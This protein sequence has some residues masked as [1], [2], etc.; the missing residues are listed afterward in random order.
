MASSGG[1]NDKGDSGKSD[2]GKSDS[3]KSDSKYAFDENGVAFSFFMA[4]LVGCFVVPKTWNLL[5]GGRGGTKASAEHSAAVKC[6]CEGCEEW[7]ARQAKRSKQNKGGGWL[8]HLTLILGWL[9]VAAS[10]AV[11]LNGKIE[12]RMYDPYAVLG[13]P[14]GA[15]EEVVRKAYKKL[16][17]KMHPD[18]LKPGMDKAATEKAFVEVSRAYQTLT[19]ADMNRRWQEE[20]DPDG[21][22]AY[23]LG[24]ALPLWMV[25]GK[26]SIILLFLYLGLFGIGVPV[27]VSRLWNRSRS[28]TKDKLLHETMQMFYRELKEGMNSRKVLEFVAAATEYQKLPSVANMEGFIAEM[29]EWCREQSVESYAVPKK[30][31]GNAAAVKAHAL[32]F[33]H[34]HRY[35]GLSTLLKEQQVQVVELAVP[36]TLGALQICLARK[37]VPVA[38]AC[39]HLCQCVVSAAPSESAHPL[40][41]LPWLDA[42]I[43]RHCCTNKRQIRSV[44]DFLDMPDEARK[45][46]LR[47]LSEEQQGAVVQVAQQVPRISI[48][49]IKLQVLGQADVTPGSVVSAQFRVLLTKHTGDAVNVEQNDMEESQLLEDGMEF[50]EDG[51]LV[52]LKKT[53]ILADK[54]V[55]PSAPV[56]APYFPLEKRPFWWVV[57]ANRAVTSLVTLPVKVSDLVP[58]V[59]KTVTMQFEAPPKTGTIPLKLIVR[60]DSLL[61]ADV[62]VDCELKIVPEGKKERVVWNISDVE[63]DDDSEEEDAEEADEETENEQPDN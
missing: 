15:A 8:S 34:T 23:K 53:R 32:L 44:Q 47:S 3:G 43:V 9:V 4:T 40:L 27:L 56:H 19:D 50:D 24:I 11:A 22:R 20:G 36:L 17:L 41:M 63:E 51:N 60:S 12:Q 31:E 59:P 54:R 7:R 14:H 25:S 38:Q 57:L 37:W 29:N 42:S 28:Y 26:S 61:G 39:M 10:L 35:P 33:A 55:N 21:A 48:Q 58:G 5:F 18:K 1:G 52:D 6:P 2:S 13:V 62:D 46:L 16:S 30:L 49:S 45:S